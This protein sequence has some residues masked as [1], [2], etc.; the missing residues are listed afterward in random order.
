[1]KAIVNTKLVMEDGIVWDGAVTYENGRIVEAGAERDV[2]IPPDA[3]ILDA[4]GKYAAPGLVDVHVH[5]ADRWQFFEEPTYCAEYFLRHGQTTVLP[6]LYSNLSF[7]ELITGVARIREAM[8][9]D[10]AGRIIAGV[11]MEGPYMNADLGS[12]Q[13]TMLWRGEILSNEY[14]PLVDYLGADARVWCVD[15]ARKGIEDFLRYVKKVNPDAVI[16]L[17]HSYANAADC[18]RIKKYGVRNQTHH[19][20]SGKAKGLAQCTIGAGCDEFALYD[21]DIYTELICDQTGVHVVP[22]LIKLV[23]RTKGVERIILITDSFCSRDNYKNA[24]GIGYGPDLNYD[25]EGHLAGSRLTLDAACRN[26]MRHTGYGLCHAIRF[27]SLNP[28][29]MLGLDRDIGSLE[30][31][32]RANIL[33]I[34]DMVNVEQVILD[35]EIAVDNRQRTFLKESMEERV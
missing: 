35:G 19:S 1:M 14:M 11:Y 2:R 10:G 13:S 18:R 12:N 15:P 33:L 28:A 17:G 23:I 27:A 32:K 20:D 26:V 9:G 3:E 7:E 34:D 4:G 16:S 29:R 25:D 6:A 31:G 30:S 8:H 24:P 5:G 21:P 22:D